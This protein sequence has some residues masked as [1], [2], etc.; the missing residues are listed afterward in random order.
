MRLAERLGQN[1]EGQRDKAVGLFHVAG[2]LGQVAVGGEANRTAHHGADSFDDAGLHFAAQFHGGKQR[3]FAA[4]QAAGHFVDGEHGRYGQAAFDGLHDAAVVIDIE[5][6]ARFDEHDVGAH[7]FGV[8]DDG[9]GFDAEGF[10]LVAGGDATGRV[11]HH[12][13]DADR[14]AAQLGPDL[15]LDR[16]EVGVEIDEK[17]VHVAAGRRAP[18]EMRA[19]VG[20]SAAS[21]LKLWNS[22]GHCSA[23]AAVFAD[24]YF[25]IHAVSIFAFCSLEYK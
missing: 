24:C 5:F 7:A 16:G 1:V 18:V 2:D 20:R 10:G 25:G 23:S 4:H 14:T 8:G 11:G 6:V 19:L 17:P 9:S 3:A 22:S 13:N 15:L 21:C 12:G